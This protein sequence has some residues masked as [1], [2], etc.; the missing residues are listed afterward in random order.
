MTTERIFTP[1]DPEV[2][3]AAER[4]G[5]SPDYV[6]D[7][8]NGTLAARARAAIGDNLDQAAM[9]TALDPILDRARKTVAD[10]IAAAMTA[11]Y[12]LGFTHGIRSL[13]SMLDERSGQRYRPDVPPDVR[14]HV[15]PD[16]DRDPRLHLIVHEYRDGVGADET[17]CGIRNLA[18]QPITGTRDATEHDCGDCTAALQR[19][20]DEAGLPTDEEYAA[21]LAADGAPDGQAAGLVQRVAVE[22]AHG[23]LT[24]AEELARQMHPSAFDDD[25]PTGLHAEDVPTPAPRGW[26]RIEG[27]DL[28]PA[29]AELVRKALAGELVD[30]T[31]EIVSFA[32]DAHC[33]WWQCRFCGRGRVGPARTETDWQDAA[34]HEEHCPHNPDHAGKI[35]DEGSPRG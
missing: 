26:E 3:A 4:T 24:G 7:A 14:P 21:T 31:Q 27:V 29:L 34:D 6:A 1:R 25:T 20:G 35:L 28:D 17:A 22:V 33:R 19:V 30:M 13:A 11:G 5:H 12:Q 10:D 15:P 32:T 2:I 16:V 9:A 18:F 8:V 23:D